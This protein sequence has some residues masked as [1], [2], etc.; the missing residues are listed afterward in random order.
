[1]S[2]N[3]ICDVIQEWQDVMFDLVEEDLFLM[4]VIGGFNFFNMIYF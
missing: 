1:M 3:I 2:F 4:V